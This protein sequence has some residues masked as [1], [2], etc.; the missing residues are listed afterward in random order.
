MVGGMKIRQ[1][2]RQQAQN[3]QQNTATDEKRST[4]VPILRVS[5]EGVYGQI[6]MKV[7]IVGG[8]AGGA[9]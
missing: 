5:K 3:Q 8:V 4:Y 2:R 9:S 1:N 6:K 7:M